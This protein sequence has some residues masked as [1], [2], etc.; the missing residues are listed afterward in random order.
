VHAL[1]KFI[2]QFFLVLTFVPW[3]IKRHSKLQITKTCT[4]VAV[5]R[6]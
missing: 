2:F 3:H 1:S 4:G 6:A 5:H